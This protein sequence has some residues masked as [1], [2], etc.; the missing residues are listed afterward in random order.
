M[1]STFTEGEPFGHDR[2]CSLAPGHVQRKDRSV[3]DRRRRLLLVVLAV[4][5]VAATASVGFWLTHRQLPV[6]VDPACPALLTNTVDATEDFGDTVTWAGQTY[7]LT[8]G[9]VRGA[10]QVGVVTCSYLADRGDSGWRVAPGPWPDGAA[11]VLPRGTSLHV[12]AE[13]RAGWGL[14]ARTSAGDRLY[15]LEEGQT[16]APAC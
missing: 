4:V 15:C 3:L 14:V 7:W 8:G 12:P 6:V 1:A 9:D 10:A 5:V 11:T 2:A 16:F 13:D